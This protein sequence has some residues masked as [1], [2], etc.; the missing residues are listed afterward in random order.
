MELTF[1]AAT[2]FIWIYLFLQKLRWS[3]QSHEANE[4]W[5]AKMKEAWK[6]LN[7]SLEEWPPGHLAEGR[8][9]APACGLSGN[10]EF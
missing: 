9:A 3:L 10:K 8:W 6:T 7:Q 5:K 4:C 1:G 2:L